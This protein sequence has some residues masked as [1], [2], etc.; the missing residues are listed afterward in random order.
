MVI[1]WSVSALRG[2]KRVQNVSVASLLAQGGVRH[3]CGTQ[4]YVDVF[5]TSLGPR[6]LATTAP[7][8]TMTKAPRAVRT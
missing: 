8:E 5:T 2:Q 4:V 6:G 1:V 3:G 7:A